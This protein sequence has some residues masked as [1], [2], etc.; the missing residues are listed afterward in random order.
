MCLLLSR[1][2]S[3]PTK[4]RYRKGNQG[5]FK[6]VSKSQPYGWEIWDPKLND[7]I[8]SSNVKFIE[9]VGDKVTAEKSSEKLREVV[10]YYRQFDSIEESPSSYQHFVGKRYYDRDEREVFKTTSV[11]SRYDGDRTPEIYARYKSARSYTEAAFTTNEFRPPDRDR[12][13]LPKDIPD[14][15]SKKRARKWYVNMFDEVNY[16]LNV[17]VVW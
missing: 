14:A 11:V 16:I 17:R 1:A 15:L 4:R 13:S 9:N 12:E 5:Y 3:T 8:V 7:I 6:G 10:F 2:I